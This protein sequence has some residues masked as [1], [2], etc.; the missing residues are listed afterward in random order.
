MLPEYI[1]ERLRRDPTP[2][3]SVVPRS[4]PVIAFGDLFSSRAATLGLNPSSLEFLDNDGNL[5]GGKD[6]RLATLES[7]GARCLSSIT[8]IQA[9]TIADDCASY[10][11]RN[12]Y[13][14]WFNQLEPMLNAVGASYDRRTACHLDLVQW[15]T[16]PKWGGLPSATRRSILKEDSQ[17]LAEQ[18]KHEGIRFLLLNGQSVIRHFRKMFNAELSAYKTLTEHGHVATRIV[19]GTIF[20]RIQVIGWST[21]IQSSFGVTTER[22]QAI[23]QVVSEIANGE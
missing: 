9:Q 19:R 10:F 22:R 23:S 17:F 1:V 2:G 15:A 12:P 8:A 14:Q 6:R 3:C 21:N 11:E 18:L 7:L 13:R 5:L 4:T 16:D 20:D